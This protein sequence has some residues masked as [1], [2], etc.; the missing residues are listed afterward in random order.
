MKTIKST[1]YT[2]VRNL[3][4]SIRLFEKVRKIQRHLS[5]SQDEIKLPQLL[6][7]YDNGESCQ[8]SGQNKLLLDFVKNGG[9]VGEFSGKG[10]EVKSVHDPHY[11]ISQLKLLCYDQCFKICGGDARKGNLFPLISKKSTGMHVFCLLVK[12]SLFLSH[13]KLYLQ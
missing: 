11:K 13:M 1:H 2:G 10:T 8:V 5:G 7:I 3:V 6:I 9:F 4:R 12:R